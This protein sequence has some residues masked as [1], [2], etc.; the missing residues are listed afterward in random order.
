VIHCHA[1]AASRWDQDGEIAPTISDTLTIAMRF[2]SAHN[3][4]EEDRGGHTRCPFKPPSPDETP[5]MQAAWQND[6]VR[7]V[8]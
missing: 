4:R 1:H 6:P 5:N 7:V 3:R 2:G 8:Q